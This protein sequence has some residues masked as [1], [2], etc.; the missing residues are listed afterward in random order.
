MP[1]SYGIAREL[2]ASMLAW[3]EVVARLA[4]ARN[5]W[6]GTTRPD[7]RPH[8]T[9]VWGL[10]FE[11]ALHFCTDGA[12]TKALNLASNPAVA[13]HLESG[14][15]A[16]MLEGTVEVVVDGAF[17]T[18]LAA[19]Y[20]AKYSIAPD[21]SPGAARTY[22]LRLTTAFAWREQDFPESATRWRFDGSAL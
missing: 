10:W 16:V 15:D 19:A 1:A 18:R 20:H 22:R 8:A 5:Y 4:A 11:E 13:V 21:L 14:D 2:T 9:P 6:I 17:L 3:A 7:G 12:S